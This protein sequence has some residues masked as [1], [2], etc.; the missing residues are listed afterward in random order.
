MTAP[1]MPDRPQPETAST[2]SSQIP[3]AVLELLGDS[4]AIVCTGDFCDLP[5]SADSA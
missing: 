3:P 2:T 1:A 5:P 4:D